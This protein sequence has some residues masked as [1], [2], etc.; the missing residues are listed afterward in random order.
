MDIQTILVTLILFL[1]SIVAGGLVYLVSRKSR[2]QVRCLRFFDKILNT[3]VGIPKELQRIIFNPFQQVDITSN[4]KESGFGL[5]LSI[6]K[7]ILS[8]MDG[9]I[10]S[11]SEVRVGSTFTVLSPLEPA[12]E[13]KG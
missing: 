7:Q 12:W 8:L 2:V 5:G 4:Q 6:V 9:K 3:G 1:A 10:K 11:V 13:N